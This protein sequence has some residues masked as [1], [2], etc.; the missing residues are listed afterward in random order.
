[1]NH[2]ERDRQVE[3]RPRSA[4]AMLGREPPSPIDLSVGQDYEWKATP[5]HDRRR[6]VVKR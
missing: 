1:M 2:Q 3:F 4:V 6:M 5:W